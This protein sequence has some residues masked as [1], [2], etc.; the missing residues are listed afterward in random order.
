MTITRKAFLKSSGVAAVG[1][2]GSAH[3]NAA[4]ART[5]GSPGFHPE[6]LPS[7][8]E[9]WDW[10]TWMA[11]LGPKYTGNPAHRTFVD[12]LES[13]LKSAGLE[14]TRDHFT[15]P[16]WEAQRWEIS[17]MPASGARTKIPVSSYFP[18]SGRTSAA[19]VTGQL[20]Y[21]GTA[22]SQLNLSGL[23]GKIA[24]VDCPSSQRRY[25]EWYAPW[26]VYPSNLVLP[27]LDRWATSPAIASVEGG[28]A[29]FKKAGA[30]GIIAAWTDLS[31]ADAADQYAPFGRAFQNIPCLYVGKAS[32]TNLRDLAGSGSEATLVL[33]AEITQDSPTDTLVAT[34]PGA[35]ADE[36]I[37]VNTHT[38]G[39]NATEENG[40]LGLI[41]LAKYLAKIPQSERKRTF[42][43][44]LATG[45]FASAYVPSIRGFIRNHPDLVKKTV[46][47]LTVE[48]LGCHEW[49]DD[50][51]KYKPTGQ[52]EIAL[53]I[54]PLKGTA[55][56][57][58]ESLEGSGA[59]RTAVVKSASPEGRF[60][61]EGN[62]LWAAGIP[63]I[64][65]IPLPN[66]LLAGPANGCI[67][68]LNG[69]L[70]HRQIQVFAKV[71]G[72]M[73]AMTVAQLKAT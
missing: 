37:I 28:L 43:F 51:V 41:A 68:K 58:L 20:A 46:A 25:K 32:G 17:A 64:G 44:V 67:E 2:L 71:L 29:T 56:I 35:S 55:D 15:L 24:V 47:A 72:K 26:G 39:P 33:E 53:A 13:Q 31:D 42:V 14:V 9:I 60:F 18:Y 63:T 38:D 4:P 66:Y 16:R 62:A 57:M 10:Q 12:F 34:L 59:G 65:Y 7:Q 23:E 1:A 73:D 27:I 3:L 61:G 21:V 49:L 8:K 48:H 54:S 22:P 36:I 30:V 40:G 69:E 5:A 52:T 45:H 11:K 50:G 70:L 6:Y 19:G